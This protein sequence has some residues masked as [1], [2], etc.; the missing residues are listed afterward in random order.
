MKLGE[1]MTKEMQIFK[2]AGGQGLEVR[3]PDLICKERF[4]SGLELCGLLR[5][6]GV[7]WASPIW[8]FLFLGFWQEGQNCLGACKKAYEV[9]GSCQRTLRPSATHSAYVPLAA[10]PSTTT[11]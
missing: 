10:R 5:V 1:P 7:A 6:P 8:L 9:C 4:G 3:A 11:G 2:K